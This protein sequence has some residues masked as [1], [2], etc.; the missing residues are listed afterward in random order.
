MRLARRW[1][2]AAPTVGAVHSRN[3]PDACPGVLSTHEAA[4]GPLARVR[5]PGGLLRERQARV[6]ADCADEFG[7]GMVHLT[8]RA[9][10]QL[11]AVGDTAKLAARLSE[12]GLLPSAGHERVRNVLAS[13]LSGLHGGLIDVRPLVGALDEALRARAELAGL[14]GRFLLA[15]DDGRGDVSGEG[16][17][18]CW[19]ATGPGEGA[20]LLDGADTGLRVAAR[21]AAAV[22]VE[23][24]CAFQDRRGRAWRV[25]E[26]DD[27]GRAAVLSAARPRARGADPARLPSSGPPPVGPHGAAV[28]AAARFG[29]LRSTALRALGEVVVTPWRT[30]VVTG[31]ARGELAAMGLVVDPAAPSL[32]V[33]ACI[34]SPRC[35]K[36]R[37]DVR[38]DAEAVLNL[39]VR[40]HFSGCE[41]RC[42]RPR[43]PHADVLAV[44]GGY[45]V[46]GTLV[47]TAELANALKGR[48]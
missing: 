41:R 47:P 23:I 13:P 39:G 14:P 2:G 5:L 38:T 42:G 48:L 17:D 1:G 11:R 15:L 40:A 19:Q 10:L 28:V 4:D 31:M 18:A 16:A 34:G 46:D 36:S 45:R 7:D 21:D 22:L 27:A 6:L 20:L 9:N 33:S 25:N 32:G 3:R 8:S 12:A 26:L 37:S 29:Q 43:E 24:A 44:E 35:A 30:V